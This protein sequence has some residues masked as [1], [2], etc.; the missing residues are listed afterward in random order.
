MQSK[1]GSSTD[2]FIFLSAAQSRRKEVRTAVTSGQRA[3]REMVRSLAYRDIHSETIVKRH[4]VKVRQ[5]SSAQG[6]AFRI[7]RHAHFVHFKCF[8]QSHPRATQRSV[9]CVIFLSLGRFTH[10]S[11]E[12]RE[13]LCSVTR[14]SPSKGTTCILACIRGEL[15]NTPIDRGNEDNV[16]SAFLWIFANDKNEH[17]TGTIK[18]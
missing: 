9:F 7:L 11:Q 1:L 5:D 2:R 16:L 15:H 18:A 10:H 6:P 17:R 13:A 4:Q 12:L 14:R 3:E 8:S